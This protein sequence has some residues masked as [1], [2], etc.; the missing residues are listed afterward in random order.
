MKK[1]I[2]FIVD[3]IVIILL[4]VLSFLAIYFEYRNM[5]EIISMSGTIT[6]VIGGCIMQILIIFL[7]IMFYQFETE[8][9]S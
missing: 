6:F 5:A 7:G 8:F 9:E 2:L 1:N 3:F 4:S